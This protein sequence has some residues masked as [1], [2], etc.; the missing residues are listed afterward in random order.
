MASLLFATAQRLGAYDLISGRTTYFGPVN[1][2]DSAGGGITD[3]AG[4]AD[5]RIFF[6]TADRLYEFD[7]ETGVT[8][9][10]GPHG[11]DGDL[12]ALGRTPLGDL[13]GGFVGPNEMVA[14]D[15]D[16]PTGSQT[17][18]AP[19]ERYR[20]DLDAV[21]DR[22]V[23][24]PDGVR[25][26]LLVF[27]SPSPGPADLFAVTTPESYFGLAR[28][29]ENNLIGLSGDGVFTMQDDGA[30][31]TRIGALEGLNGEAVVGAGVLGELLHDNITLG[32]ADGAGFGEEGDD[33]ITGNEVG[34]SL[35]G[36]A[37]HDL[38]RGLGGADGIEG[39]AGRDVLF[40]GAGGD[41]IGG[42]KG[43]D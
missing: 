2:S 27:A 21:G 6:S 24:G 15:A 8:T 11:R 17:V 3:V 1:I 33:T 25:D 36:G 38:I 30:A 5:G 7:A 41:T 32:E 19:D 23:I 22:I 43:A 35:F 31:Q 28:I 14:M 39:D 10:L 16:D 4:H 26:D 12:I 29:G 37:G 18:Q 40:G 13:M 34:D 42:G 20:G 9:Q